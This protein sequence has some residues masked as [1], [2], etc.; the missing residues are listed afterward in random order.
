MFPSMPEMTAREG[1]MTWNGHETWYRVVGELD[2]EAP[3]TPVVILHGGPGAAHDYC[4]P[5]AE[6]SRFGRACVLYD[7]LG[8]G[9]SQHL[10]DAP[11][12]FW[13]PELFKDE[14]VALTEHLGVAG[15]HAVVG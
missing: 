4:E 13:T 12:E 5:I 8:C 2:A 9:K 10:P 15:R 3:T 14:L 7:Q 1:R 6:L 11:E